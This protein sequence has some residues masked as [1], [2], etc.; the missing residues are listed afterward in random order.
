[1]VKRQTRKAGKGGKAEKFPSL[2][3]TQSGIDKWHDVMFDKLGWMIL[4]KE[5]GLDYKVEAYKKSLVRLVAMIKHVSSEYESHN[6]KHDLNV[7]LLNVL[8]LKSFVDKHL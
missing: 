3:G 2:M 4:A 5:K 7:T 1:M 8:C 6:R